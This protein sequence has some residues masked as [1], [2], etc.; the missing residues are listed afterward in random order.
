MKSNYRRVILIMLFMAMIIN[1]MDRAALS[2]AM[3]FMA[4]H[5]DLTPAEKGMVF[6][7]FFIG[8]A[9]FN[10]IGGYLADRIGPKKVLGGAMTV[11]SLFCGATAGVFNFWSLLVV[12]VLFGVGEGPISTAANKTV[13]GWFPLSERA[14]AVGINQ[15]GGPLGG[16]LA[17]PVV[18]F[19]ALQFGWQWSFIAIAVFGLIWAFLWQRLGADRAADHPRVTPSELTLIE[20]GVEKQAPAAASA[21]KHSPLAIIKT[22]AVLFMAVSLFCYNYILFFF[23][24]WFPTFLVDAKGI[25]LKEMSI[26]TALPWLVGA[27][28]YMSGGFIIDAVYRRTGR[29]MFS[30]KVVL[31]SCLLVAALCLT[32]IGR[33]GTAF[34]AVALMTVAIGF[35]MLA[36]PAYWALIQDS[37]PPEQ[38]GTAG[39]FMHGMANLSGIVGPT[40]TGFLVQST[41][42]YVTAFVLAGT[43]G[44]VGA[45]VVAFFVRKVGQPAAA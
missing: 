43:L 8:Y 5:F 29:Q 33:T 16:A 30:R 45:L 11:W 14:R 10:F 26:V 1:Y 37:V 41:H 35:L 3:P 31:V 6:S 42:S 34:S 17:G 4:E 27:M 2:I 44:I 13:S 22:P 40:L 18:G 9:L 23:L 38:V 19:M 12:R 20:E 32:V 25:S 24:T 7:S 28:G 15:A 36:A 39:G 21:P